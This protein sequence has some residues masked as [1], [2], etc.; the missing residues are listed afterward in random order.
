MAYQRKKR[1]QEEHSQLSVQSQKSSLFASPDLET[2]DSE[3][4]LSDGFANH[5]PSLE[6]RRQRASQPDYDFGGI[7]LFAPNRAVQR[8]PPSPLIQAERKPEGVSGGG[9]AVNL[10]PKGSGRPLPASVVSKFVQAGY[11]EVKKARLHV[12]DEAAQSIQARAYTQKE[13]IVVQSSGANDPK[14]LGHEATHVVQQSQ[15]ALKPDVKGAPINANPALE[16]NA[17]DNGDRIARNEP[18]MVKGVRTLNKLAGT[19]NSPES[20]QPMQRAISEPQGNQVMQRKPGA[21]RRSNSLPTRLDDPQPVDSLPRASTSV[22]GSEPERGELE[23][24]DS[25]EYL[26]FAIESESADLGSGSDSDEEPIP[27]VDRSPGETDSPPTRL[28]P[29]ANNLPRR[30]S[31]PTRLE[32][33]PVDSLSPAARVTTEIEDNPASDRGQASGSNQPNPPEDSGGVM[34]VDELRTEGGKPKSIL[35]RSKLGKPILGT[36]TYRQIYFKLMAYDSIRYS[37][38]KGNQKIRRLKKIEKLI[39]KW[40]DRGKL[41]W[42]R[43]GATQSKK[44]LINNRENVLKR[45]KGQVRKEYESQAAQRNQLFNQNEQPQ[46]GRGFRLRHDYL[47]VRT[48]E[49]FQ[50]ATRRTFKRRDEILRTMDGLLDQYLKYKHQ[51][52]T[53]EGQRKRIELIHQIRELAQLWQ[54]KYERKIAI[55]KKYQDLN[56]RPGAEKQYKIPS[57]LEQIGDIDHYFS[58]LIAR[59]T[60]VKALHQGAL[61]DRLG[62]SNPL[63]QTT[64]KTLAKLGDKYDQLKAKYGNY[65]GDP[66]WFFSHA[67]PEIVHQIA[68]N[69]GQK[70]KFELELRFPVQPGVFVGGRIMMQVERKTE[71][72]YKVNFE[73]AFQVGGTVGVALLAGEVGVFAEIVGKN[74]ETVGKLIN[75]AVYRRFRE[76]N[77]IPQRVTNRI[78][79]GG[80]GMSAP[81]LTNREKTDQA[82][83][84]AEAWAAE[85]ENQI[86]EP[87][88]EDLRADKDHPDQKRIKKVM[89]EKSHVELS[90]LAGFR[91]EYNTAP[92]GKRGQTGKA[93]ANMMSGRRY[94]KASIG[95]RLGEREPRPEPN[96]LGAA[97]QA[98]RGRRANRLELSTDIDLS[99]FK[100]SAKLKLHWLG[101][102]AKEGEW[103]RFGRSVGKIGKWE[104]ELN[105]QL[106]LSYAQ[107]A[108]GGV[109]AIAATQVSNGII[110]LI[111]QIREKA[112]SNGRLKS[113]GDVVRGITGEL[114]HVAAD[115]ETAAAGTK[116]ITHMKKMKEHLGQTGTTSEGKLGL[117]LTYKTGRE[118][119]PGKYD[120]SKDQ[121]HELNVYLVKDYKLSFAD[122]TISYSRGERLLQWK[123]DWGSKTS[124]EFMGKTLREDKKWPKKEKKAAAA[125]PAS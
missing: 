15:M 114:L 31:P 87:Q 21:P 79:G 28:G 120:D 63:D 49:E 124:F 42:K 2:A 52:V 108:K 125:P 35:G 44:D 96:R 104:I 48:V 111:K 5:A 97:P 75:L 112:V 1:T 18:V 93:S 45:L 53:E 22:I 102:Q 116:D 27:G 81:G 50:D 37:K 80:K 122:S 85:T 121:K 88:D 9:S 74:P 101:D 41:Y 86:F 109:A 55:Y 40:L 69:F 7:P 59:L 58:G 66:V 71:S 118:A 84:R 78:W 17:D 60:G 10:T 105:G 67:V 6:M 106:Q 68:P 117:N 32:P 24:Q 39:D 82:Y 73:G 43:L 61:G 34:T 90:G 13:N 91:A 110:M 103:G 36:G 29:Q 119:K 64:N 12:D 23:S 107:I 47:G 100:A 99:F 89:D 51:R 11:P 3:E 46:P 30:D 54:K 4:S 92:V 26:T 70:S 62:R 25:S 77:V 56:Q 94:D 19:T 95:E 83:E 123:A 65:T 98:T 38:E 20:S 115:I 72:E 57:E 14:L 8:R 33:Q 76:S 113:N 16:Q